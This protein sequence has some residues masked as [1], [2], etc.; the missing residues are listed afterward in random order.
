MFNKTDKKINKDKI[1]I[2][3]LFDFLKFLSNKLPYVVSKEKLNEEGFNDELINKINIINK[4]LFEESLFIET[5]N[6]DKISYSIQKEGLK[7]LEEIKKDQLVENQTKILHNQVKFNFYLV[8]FSLFTLILG[9]AKTV[10]DL[11]KWTNFY[12]LFYL[13]TWLFLSLLSLLFFIENYKV[14]K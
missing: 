3:Y 7:Y 8:I 9:T 13:F 14:T 1:I 4:N 6:K 2:G 5:K 11:V 12:I 10:L